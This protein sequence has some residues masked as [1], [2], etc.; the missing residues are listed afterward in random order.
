M[1]LSQKTAVPGAHPLQLQR[2]NGWLVSL[3]DFSVTPHLG[4][5]RAKVCPTP[6]KDTGLT[7][8]QETALGLATLLERSGQGIGG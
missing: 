7:A 3:E 1:R 2:G 8:W 6:G 4:A 5:W